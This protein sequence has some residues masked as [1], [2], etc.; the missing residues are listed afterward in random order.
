LMEHNSSDDNLSFPYYWLLVDMG[1][2]P[3]GKI[4]ED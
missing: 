1:I 4:Q 2:F 3:G